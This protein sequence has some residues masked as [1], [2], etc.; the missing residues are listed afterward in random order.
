MC[1]LALYNTATVHA[2]ACDKRAK[3]GANNMC[4]SNYAAFTPFKKRPCSTIRRKENSRIWEKSGVGR[5]NCVLAWIPV[6][7]TYLKWHKRTWSLTQGCYH[8]PQTC[9]VGW[10]TP[11]QCLI[12]YLAAYAEIHDDWWALAQI[13]NDGT[14]KG[15]LMQIQGVVYGQATKKMRSTG[16]V[17][18]PVRGAFQRCCKRFPT[19]HMSPTSLERL[20]Y[21][22]QGPKKHG[23]THPN[24]GAD[25]G[26]H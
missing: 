14:R 11:G 13:S 18:V 3:L 22:R 16:E 9:K 17:A 5:G 7:P 19:A 10:Q 4:M 21:G 20:C 6:V 1:T 24:K 2:R 23:Y 15:F 12:T 25:W 26:R 8:A